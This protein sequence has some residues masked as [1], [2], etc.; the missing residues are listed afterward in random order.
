[1]NED[2]KS[3]LIAGH[4]YLGAE[5][6]R[7]ARVDGWTVSAVSKSGDEDSVACDLTDRPALLKFA[8]A[9]TPPA[10]TILCA[11]SGRGGADAY[12]AVFLDGTR[13][14]LEA[15]PR[16]RLLFV[17]STSVY[18]Q[19]DG[20][21]VDEDSPA[22]PERETSRL[23]LEA[24]ALALAAGGTVARLSGIYGP[25]RSVILRR[26]LSG[27]A[28]VEED[29][30]RFLN[31]IHRDDAARAL[32][33]LAAHP[34]WSR[35]GIFNVT[36]SVPVRQ[37]E[38]YEVLAA[39]FDRPVPPRGPRPVGRKRAWTHKKVSN[40][41]LLSTGWS[42]RFPAFLDAAEDIAPTLGED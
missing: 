26:F 33:H 31:Q 35:G 19:T 42:P 8:A 32:L 1:M 13:H 7:Q 10:V 21:A 18:G 25:G 37:L 38:C 2:S 6:A 20:S 14:L 23:L 40:A 39:A 3:L 30:R 15:F 12:R 27:D 36:D 24:E 4:G 17:S 28:V 34:E 41:R 5:V 9:A 16:T 22:E 11:S 29:G